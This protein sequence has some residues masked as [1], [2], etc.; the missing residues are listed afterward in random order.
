MDIDEFIRQRI[1][2]YYWKDDTNCAEASLK[3]LAEVFE[4]ELNK[5]V[6]DAA[7]GM[8]GAGE[9]GAQCG[10][11]EGVLMFLGIF[12][13]KISLPNIRI[14]SLCR[15]YASQFEAEFGSLICSVLRPEGFNSENP[16]HIC[17]ELTCN[18]TEFAIDFVFCNIQTVVM[19]NKDN[20]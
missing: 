19:E 17:E 13:K 7:A 5:Q 8:H 9:Y 20:E 11:V 18:A 16:P 4:I 1:T 14:T 10:L 15:E 2:E 12:G 6:L 3:I